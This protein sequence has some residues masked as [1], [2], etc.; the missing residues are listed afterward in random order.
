MP[1]VGGLNN[2]QFSAADLNNDAT[3]DLVIFDRT[4]DRLMTFVNEGIAD[5]VNY[6]YAPKYEKNFPD[7]TCWMLMKDF[8]CDGIEDIFAHIGLGVQV[9]KGFY[10]AGNELCFT[11]YK[12][13]LKFDSFAGLFNIS[14]SLVDIP[15]I[16]DIDND[17]DLDILTF[18]SGGGWIDYFENMSQDAGY[19]CDSFNYELTEHCWGLMFEPATPRAKWLLQNC[20][21]RPEGI[22]ENNDDE[23]EMR[24]GGPFRH[25]G[26]TLLAFDNDGDGDKELILGDISW[27]DLVYLTN[28]GSPT[29]ALLTEQDTLFPNYSVPANIQWF[30]AAFY[31]DLNNDGANDIVASPNS[32]NGMTNVANVWY[33]KNIGTNNNGTFIYQTDSL[34]TKDMVDVGEGA[35]PVFADVNNDG[36]TDILVT[37]RNYFGAKSQIEYLQN[38]GTDT[39]PVYKIISKNWMNLSALN[40][41]SLYPA[42]GDLDNDGKKEMVLGNEGGTLLFYENTG[43]GA[44]VNDNFVL[45]NPSYFSIDVGAFSTPVIID[46]DGDDLLDIVIGEDNGSLNFCRNTGT[47]STANFSSLQTSFGNVIVNQGAQIVGFSIPCFTKLNNEITWTLL[48]GC[49]GGNVF[50]YNGIEGN[51][52][53]TFNLVDTSF[54]DIYVGSFSAPSATD[55]NADGIPEIAI[56]NYR[57]GV[58]VYDTSNAHNYAAIE[59]TDED[60]VLNLYPNPANDFITLTSNHDVIKAEVFDVLGRKLYDV[61]IN[62]RREFTLSTSQLSVALYVIRIT[63]ADGNCTIKFLKN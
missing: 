33:Y 23:E 52:S 58:T 19:G 37:N 61:D 3:P 49:E 1:W 7:L 6:H 59:I 20:P 38:V 54:A 50:Q 11:T 48:V 16:C 45:T 53:G 42:F 4:G 62:N 55:I 56:G 5:S 18:E 32:E 39:L 2:P 35:A 47:V 63:S 13:I 31:L 43:G 34:F 21:W 14:V 44:G 12:K 36:L 25:S 29:A 15:A 51:L 27:E 24:G 60:W 9:F 57:G 40:L 28:G 41:K 17:S 22:S 26:S 30:P 8:N 10:N 46:V